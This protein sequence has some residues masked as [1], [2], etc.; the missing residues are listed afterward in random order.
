VINEAIILAGGF[1]TRLKSMIKDIPKPM[2]D[3]NGKPF[4]E[5]LLLNLKKKGIDRVVLAVGYKWEIIKNYFGEKYNN[6]EI[7]YSI[8]DNPL[9]TGGAIKQAMN[10]TESK[11]VLMLNGDTFFDINLSKFFEFHK[12]RTSVLSLALKKMVNFHRYGAVEID[13][14][15]KVVAFLEK[16]YRKE[17]LINAGVYLLNKKFF[18]SLK[19]TERFSFEKDFLEKNYKICSFYGLPFDSYFIDIGVPDDYA[20][21]KRDFEKIKY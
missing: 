11:D 5:Y 10:F 21:A 7:T 1:G 19:L 8:E 17:G 14:N 9:G 15:N 12:G 2:A 4:L 6:I 18:L 20:K 3:I 16:K 13:E